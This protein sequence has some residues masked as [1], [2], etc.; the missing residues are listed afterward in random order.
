[1]RALTPWLLDFANRLVQLDEWQNNP[2]EIPKVTWLS[3]LYNP[4][5]SSRLSAR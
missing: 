5:P 3:G 1:M 2:A 4:S